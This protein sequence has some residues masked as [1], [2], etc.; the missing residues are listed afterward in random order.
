ME[1]KKSCFPL[2][3]REK[4][5]EKQ[6]PDRPEMSQKHARPKKEKKICLLFFSFFEKKSA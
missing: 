4:R 1:Q 6:T 2:Q 3:R 5:R